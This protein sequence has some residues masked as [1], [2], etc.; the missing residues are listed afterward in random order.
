[1]RKVCRAGQ[2]RWVAVGRL[3]DAL[4]IAVDDHRM[5]REPGDLVQEGLL[6]DQHGAGGILQH[7]LEPRG[8]I[9]GVHGDIG[10]ARLLNAQDPH[11]HIEGALHH[12]AD[13]VVGTDP[14]GPQGMCQCVGARVEFA[15][16][17]ISITEF[18]GNVLGGHGGL[19]LEHLVGAHI[20]G[21]VRIGVV[22]L[23]EEFGTFGGADDVHLLRLCLGCIHEGLQ[24]QRQVVHQALHAL[25]VVEVRGIIEAH[26]RLFT[27][28]DDEGE[29]EARDLFSARPQQFQALETHLAQVHRVVFVHEETG[30]ERGGG[31]QGAGGLDLGQKGVAELLNLERLGLQVL[32]D[33]LQRGLAIKTHPHGQAVDEQADH[34]VGADQFG[35]PPGD[36]HPEDHVLLLAVAVQQDRPRR[37]Q[38]GAGSD[39]QTARRLLQGRCHLA[40]QD[41]CMPGHGEP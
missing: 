35:G 36:G 37:L 6:R 26:V 7:V 33:L 12:E 19:G 11:E 30:E 23:R 40:V 8:G 39:P 10:P 38:Q 9:L 2:G 22:Q 27:R 15:I 17:E 25:L 24:D 14:H 16:G 13:L 5:L 21:V 32:Q 31:R 1:M 4:P 41:V 29:V 28:G 20:A 18:D 3:R 34:L